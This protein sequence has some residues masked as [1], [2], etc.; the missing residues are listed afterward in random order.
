M[1]EESGSSEHDGSFRPCQVTCSNVQGAT[2]PDMDAASGVVPKHNGSLSLSVSDLDR[3]LF[4]R[5]HAGCDF[6][7]N[8]R[9]LSLHAWACT[10]AFSGGVPQGTSNAGSCRP[11]GT[12]P[13]RVRKDAALRVAGQHSTRLHRLELQGHDGGPER[14][15]CN[16]GTRWRGFTPNGPAC[17]RSLHFSKTQAPQT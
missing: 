17:W 10:A 8:A 3:G 5:H 11:T 4:N 1:C 16:L 15:S 7:G 12:R 13:V 9:T 2:T 6:H 14:S